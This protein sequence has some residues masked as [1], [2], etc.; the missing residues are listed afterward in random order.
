MWKKAAYQGLIFEHSS[1]N[2]RIQSREWTKSE[3]LWCPRQEANVSF[4]RWFEALFS[5]VWILELSVYQL[6]ILSFIIRVREERE[7][8]TQ[9]RNEWLKRFPPNGVVMA[10]TVCCLTQYPFETDFSCAI[11]HYRSWKVRYSL[12]QHALHVGRQCSG[13]WGEWG[14]L[15]EGLWEDSLCCQKEKS[16]N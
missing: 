5:R 3:W 1:E 12:S 11:S 9:N 10:E 16:P 14:S 13:Q 15:P 6:H 4:G 7:G 8:K 2:E